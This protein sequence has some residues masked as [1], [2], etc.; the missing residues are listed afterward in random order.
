LIVCDAHAKKLYEKEVRKLE[1]LAFGG[2]ESGGA[3]SITSGGGKDKSAKKKVRVRASAGGEGGDGRQHQQHQ[4]LGDQDD[5]E[6]EE[7]SDGTIADRDTERDAAA[8]GDEDVNSG[9]G[10]GKAKRSV[11]YETIAK[12]DKKIRALQ[13][14]L[15]ELRTLLLSVVDKQNTFSRQLRHISGTHSDSLVIDEDDEDDEEA[16]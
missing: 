8:A 2:A 10:S 5:P 6:D 3:G 1:P 12:Q 4:Q 11:L 13:N 14:D 16:L 7:D 9:G 15:K